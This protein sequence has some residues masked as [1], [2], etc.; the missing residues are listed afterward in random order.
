MEEIQGETE[1]VFRLGKYVEGGAHPLKVKF[2]MQATVNKTL[3]R[4][5]KLAGIEDLKNV[6]IRHD[7]NEEET[8][9]DVQAGRYRRPQ[10]CMGKT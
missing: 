7:V 3:F 9:Q 8:L 5:Y 6:W 4:T 2:Q 1:E 10:K